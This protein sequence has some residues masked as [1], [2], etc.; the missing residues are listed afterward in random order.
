MVDNK[1][2]L[3]LITTKDNTLSNSELIERGDELF[4]NELPEDVQIYYA[5]N[6]PYKKHIPTHDTRHIFRVDKGPFIASIRRELE[7]QDYSGLDF[8]FQSKGQWYAVEIFGQSNELFYTQLIKWTKMS[9]ER[10][11]VGYDP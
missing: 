6:T 9:I 4:R 10:D 1:H 11:G 8:M 2:V 7:G 5:I 3:V